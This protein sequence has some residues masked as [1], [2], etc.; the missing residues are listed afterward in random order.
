MG[1][2]CYDIV[3]ILLDSLQ[4]SHLCLSEVIFSQVL[5]LVDQFERRQRE[6]EL[7][8]QLDMVGVLCEAHKHVCKRQLRF[9]QHKQQLLVLQTTTGE[10]QMFTWPIRLG[11]VQSRERVRVPYSSTGTRTS[12]H[13]SGTISTLV[14]S[15]TTHCSGAH[16]DYDCVRRI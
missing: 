7:L 4:M 14:G 15:S 10:K 13:I 1:Y 9:Y 6:R 8:P 3:L 2:L 12:V 5:P 16:V 11:T